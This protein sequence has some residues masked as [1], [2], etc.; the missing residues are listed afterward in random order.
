MFKSTGGVGPAVRT[1]NDFSMYCPGGSLL[2]NS[3]LSFLPKKFLDINGQHNNGFLI[4]GDMYINGI[5][6]FDKIHF[7]KTPQANCK[8]Q[9]SCVPYYRWVTS[10]IAVLGGR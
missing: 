3:G 6:N 5:D 9:D 8:S 10:Y 2:F 7:W 1:G 4:S